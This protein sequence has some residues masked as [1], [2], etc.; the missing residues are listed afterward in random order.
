MWGKY[1]QCYAVLKQ[2]SVILQLHGCCHLF[3]MT[4]KKENQYGRKFRQLPDEP[5]EMKYWK[6]KI[7]SPFHKFVMAVKHLFMRHS[8]H[9][10]KAA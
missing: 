7:N 5:Y 8:V 10:T 2:L 6:E 9:H 3:C 4:N 1:T